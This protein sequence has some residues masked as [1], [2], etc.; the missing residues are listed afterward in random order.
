MRI[1][2]WIVTVLT[3]LLLAASGVPDV[4]MI[5]AA[6][7]VFRHLGYPDYLLPFIGVAKILGGL[8]IIQPWFA[9]LKEW[10]YAGLAIDVVGAAYSHLAVGDG[11]SGWVPPVVALALI[12]VSY[13]L[14]RKTTPKSESFSVY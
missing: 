14:H 1:A 10:A 11:P 2:Y 7:E 4:L 9:R 12:L 3:G 5:P 6:L 8:T 13:G